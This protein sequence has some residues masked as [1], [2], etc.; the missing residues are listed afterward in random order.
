MT[1][2]KSISFSDQ[3]NEWMKA[4]IASGQYASESEIIRDLIRHAQ[5]DEEQIERIRE[6]LRAGEES[7]VGTATPEEIRQRVRKRLRDDG[8]L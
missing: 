6:A 8:R 3:H 5:N 2:R 1:V 7:G 4:Q